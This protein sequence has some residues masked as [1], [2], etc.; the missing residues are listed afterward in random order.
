MWITPTNK[1]DKQPKREI[2]KEYKLAIHRNTNGHYE[3]MLNLT[4]FK[5]KKNIVKQWDN[6]CLSF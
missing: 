4:T 2:S 6:G 3:K 1:K 5:K